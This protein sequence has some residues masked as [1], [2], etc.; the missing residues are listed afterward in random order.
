MNYEL[1][2]ELRTDLQTANYFVKITNYE[3]RTTNLLH[4][5]S[6]WITNY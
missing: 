5:I 2:Y 6:N 3:L 1:D 4:K